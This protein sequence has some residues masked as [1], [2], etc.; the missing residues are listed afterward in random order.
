MYFFAFGAQQ[1]EIESSSALNVL[2]YED[3]MQAAGFTSEMKLEM[4]MLGRNSILTRLE[5]I[6]DL[7]TSPE[8]TAQTVDL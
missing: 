7:Y 1:T 5:N 4:F 8:L 6:A 2:G 3:L